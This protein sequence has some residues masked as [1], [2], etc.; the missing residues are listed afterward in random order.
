MGFAFLVGT[1]FYVTRRLTGLLVVGMVIHAL[2]DFGAL[3]TEHSGGDPSPIGGILSWVTA[4]LALIVLAKILRSPAD[5]SAE[6]AQL[7]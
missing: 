7:A 2:W 1:A 5:T 3:S 4:I 6:S